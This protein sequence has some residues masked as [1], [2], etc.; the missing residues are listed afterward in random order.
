MEIATKFTIATEDVTKMLLKLTK[1]LAHEKFSEILDPNILESYIEEQFNAKYLV[2][3]M[4]SMSN[5]WLTVYVDD[6]LAGYAKITSKG[7]KPLSLEN[8]HALRIADFAVLRKYP[9]E[10]IKKS[11][12]DKCLSVCKHVE[13]VWINEYMDNPIISFF[14]SNGFQK[15]S[16]TPQHDELDL[17]SVYLVYRYNSI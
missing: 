13:A 16:E 6:N 14:E 7:K 8:N 17:P 15:Q 5:Q 12:L 1:D 3:E 10:E 9:E 4:N 2:S 11:L